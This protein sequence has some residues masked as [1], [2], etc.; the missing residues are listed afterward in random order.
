MNSHR[1]K[2]IFEMERLFA[3]FAIESKAI[4]PEKEKSQSP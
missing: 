1:R 3:P 2:N 4:S